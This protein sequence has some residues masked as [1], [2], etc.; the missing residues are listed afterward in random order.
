MVI[1]KRTADKHVTNLLKKL[2]V[3]S[4]EQVAV[5]MAE[6]RAQLS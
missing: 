6:R 5:R 1:S 2:N 3:H 4:R